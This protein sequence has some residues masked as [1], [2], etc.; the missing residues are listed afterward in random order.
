M[1]TTLMKYFKLFSLKTSPESLSNQTIRA[2]YKNETA[3]IELAKWLSQNS[4][5]INKKI[6][7]KTIAKNARDLLAIFSIFDNEALYDKP[8]SPTA[9]WLI[10][11]YY[12]LDKSYQAIN[13]ELTAKLAKK[14]ELPLKICDCFLQ[15]NDSNFNI[16]K[17]SEFLQEFQKHRPLTISELW[18]IPLCLRIILLEN[19]SVIAYN[20]IYS[21]NIQD[22]AQRLF[23]KISGLKLKDQKRILDKYTSYLNHDEFL[24]TFYYLTQQDRDIYSVIDW[25][26]D[27]S[28]NPEELAKTV[29]Y[30][31]ATNTNSIANIV[32]SIKNIDDINWTKWLEQNCFV[33]K[34]L[35]KHTEFSELEDSSKYILREKIINIAKHSKL[36]E[37]TI[38]EILVKLVKETNN[39]IGYFLL[40]DGTKHLEH[41]CCYTPPLGQQI[42]RFI[43]KNNIA[44]MLTA[45]LSIASIILYILSYLS[46]SVVLL[47]TFIPFALEASFAIFNKLCATILEPNKILGYNYADAIPQEHSTLITIPCLLI[48]KE[49]I[50]ELIRNLEINYI[51]SNQDNLYFALTSDWTDSNSEE[52]NLDT[53][54]LEYSIG[55]IQELNN[56]Y[57]CNKFF[58]FHRKKLYN[59]KQRCYMGWERKRG[60]LYELGQL[61]RGNTNTSFLNPATIPNN[62]KYII[63]LDSDTLLTPGAASKLIGKLAY[64]LK[65]FGLKRP[66]NILQPRITN[67]YSP[68]KYSSKYQK[69]ATLNAGFDPYVSGLSETYQDLFAE[70]NYVGK[71]I[72]D[73]DS[74]SCDVD[75]KIP[76]NL[77]LSHDLLEGS[78]AS[79]AFVS[80]VELTEEYP[81]NYIADAKRF[82]RWVRGD[83]QLLPFI[84]KNI[85]HSLLAPIKM[86][87]NLRRSILPIL[88]VINIWAS[89]YYLTPTNALLWQ[90]NILLTTNFAKIIGF[91]CAITNKERNIYLAS[92]FFTCYK[93]TKNLIIEVF[94]STTLYAH[95]AYL[96]TKAILVTLYR[97]Y[98]S[99]RNLLEWQSSSTSRFSSQS[100]AYYLQF[101]G[102]SSI[103]GVI[104]LI[105]PGNYLVY[106]IASLWLFAPIIMYFL[107]NS[108]SQIINITNHLKLEYTEIGMRIW[109]FYETFCN[110]ESNFLPID[111]YQEYEGDKLAKRTSPTNIGMYLLSTVA[112]Y[113]FAWIDLNN[114]LTRIEKCLATVVK[115]P[116]Y[117]GH[118]YNWYSTETLE[119]LAPFYVS[120]V[121][122]GNLASHLVTL[123]GALKSWKQQ[124]NLNRN[125]INL[126]NKLY[127][128]ANSITNN[129]NFSFLLNK[130]RNLLSI[131]YDTSTDKLADSCYDMLASEAR[132][133]YFFAIA[134]GDI[135]VDSWQRLGRFLTCWSGRAALLSWSGSMFEYLM[136]P[137]VLREA[138]HA[139]LGQT[140]RIVIKKQIEYARKNK[141]WGISEAAFNA[142]DPL[143]N[144]QYSN[145]GV[146]DLG[147]QRSLAK[148]Y[149]VAPYAS[150]MA[151]QYYPHQAINNLRELK[152]LGAYGK[153]GFYD[154]VDFTSSRT[155]NKKYAIVKNYYAHHHGMSLVAIFN[156]LNN[157]KMQD[158]FYLDPRIEA[159]N[160][161]LQEKSPQ[162]VGFSNFKNINQSD[163][164][165]AFLE[166]SER[167][168]HNGKQTTKQL[169]LLNS[170]NY[171]FTIDNSCEIT[172]IIENLTISPSITITNKN[173]N[174]KIADNNGTA[175][176]D[177]NKAS[178]HNNDATL[179]IIPITPNEHNFFLTGYG[180]KLKIINESS[181]NDKTIIK[182]DI[183]NNFLK[184]TQTNGGYNFKSKIGD[185]VL[186]FPHIYGDNGWILSSNNNSYNLLLN[187]TNRKK[188]TLYFWYYKQSEDANKLLT[189][190]YLNQP[191][192]FSIED[193]KAWAVGQIELFQTR[194]NPQQIA[195]YQKLLSLLLTHNGIKHLS[196]RINSENYLYALQD[197]LKAWSFWR[198]RGFICKLTIINEAKDSFADKINMIINNFDMHDMLNITN[199]YDNTLKKSLTLV[200]QNGN[201]AEQICKFQ[202]TGENI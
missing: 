64:K 68:D 48:N 16:Y 50:D 159:Y 46:N 176:F 91:T 200:A 96:N 133:S 51:I 69:L 166:K 83:W 20:L 165:H 123:A 114:A 180:A 137:L 39:L 29:E 122:S 157:D 79:C 90:I 59:P 103:I 62:I 43:R 110:E 175:V 42:T 139:I 75:G 37:I 35:A 164:G 13:N 27:P 162:Q 71:A 77:I 142:L 189:E 183:P 167:I 145:F 127:A 113:D 194:A 174:F 11:N 111:N 197:L 102:S 73:I 108:P 195:S 186:Y 12:I 41:I 21:A 18:A 65:Y 8:I 10:D 181:D 169:I 134:K 115:L 118:L 187:F 1:M 38:A 49:V 5:T 182:I 192:S 154:A 199:K 53:K 31:Q 138:K 173:H 32:K 190:D 188:F 25:L 81:L 36:D 100:I 170:G 201:I 172:S 132:L 150:L 163:N 80:D 101:L 152:K 106:I 124:Q 107:S 58:I 82:V 151:A 126:I 28:K 26:N 67:L 87:D 178:F 56:K 24:V 14:I 60:K 34:K 47:V 125:T 93:I 116:K 146:P 72:Y 158:Y 177:T 76:E 54:L 3:F 57:S 74:F 55:K 153:Y 161:L 94:L 30:K 52:T 2:S 117:N 143:F 128:S 70:G 6:N 66:Y 23:I 112:A 160:I 129:M 141:P 95:N 198:K 4:H 105:L 92:Y 148:N 196:F 22:I 202:F 99:K 156:L 119:P 97:L 135:N 155:T 86:L 45:N 147:L 109:R 193:Q 98:I 191:N 121:D 9:K 120:T 130:K 17:F 78:L 171:S 149:V 44:F 33:D 136:P 19:V 15:H 168:I 7:L 40:G 88:F 89:A 179:E 104:T 185:M 84:F 140:N 85:C 61:L 131:G 63:T 144:Y 184:P